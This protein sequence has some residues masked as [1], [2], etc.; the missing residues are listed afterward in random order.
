MRSTLSEALQE[1]LSLR[2]GLGFKLRDETRLLRDY[3]CLLERR[4]CDFITTR[5]AVEWATKPR[6]S[7][8]S[9]WASRLRMVRQFAIHRSAADPRTQVPPTGTLP[10]RYRRKRPYL[11]CNAE[12]VRLI[13]AARQ[14]FTATGMRPQTYAT[15][16]G[17]LAVTALR[18][19]EVVALDRDDVDLSEGILT[20]RQSKFG[21]S[22][23]VPVHPS[24]LHVLQRYSDHRDRIYPNPNT[25]SFFLAERGNRL[26][27]WSVRWTFIQ[28]SRKIGLRC[29]TDSHGPRLHDLRHAF[30][31]RTLLDW[32]RDGVDVEARIS[33]L[34]TYLGHGHVTDTYWYISATPELLHLAAARLENTP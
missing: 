30:A 24:T 11:Y 25:P 15:L 32:Y 31:V 7:Q 9:H 20:V 34:A 16:F 10:F 19:G 23:M 33:H 28:L 29:P 1:Y 21:K 6:H 8:R 22:R 18:V 14:L 13:R 4:G 2:R 26:T 27:H 17:V 12:I 3:I 5:L